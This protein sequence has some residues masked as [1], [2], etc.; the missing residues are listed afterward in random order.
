MDKS[1]NFKSYY[2]CDGCLCD[3]EADRISI[4]ELKPQSP[5]YFREKQSNG[6]YQYVFNGWVYCKTHGCHMGRRARD[7]IVAI[8]IKRADDNKKAKKEA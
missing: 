8:T 6:K 2:V 7:E 5:M 4:E 1:K 3:L